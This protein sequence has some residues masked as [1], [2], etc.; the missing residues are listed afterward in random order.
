MINIK[1]ENPDVVFRLVFKYGADESSGYKEYNFKP[2]QPQQPGPPSAKKQKIETKSLF[3]SQLSIV[4][5]NAVFP[6]KTEV[7]YQNPN[8]NSIYGHVPIR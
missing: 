8:V 2:K 7:L 3:A 4:R 6:E 5:L 1:T